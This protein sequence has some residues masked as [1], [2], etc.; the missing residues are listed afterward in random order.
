MKK[1]Q[2]YKLIDLVED[3]KKVDVM[4]KLHLKDDSKFM[5][6]QYKAEKDKLI[7]FLIDKLVSPEVRSARSMLTI[8]I[9][10]DKFYND[11]LLNDDQTFQS[12]ELSQLEMAL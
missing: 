12:D 9:I 1:G 3:I 4:V 7:G 8:K 6:D 5:L 2:L 11:N 10:I